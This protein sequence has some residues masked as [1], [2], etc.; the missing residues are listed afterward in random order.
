MDENLKVKA[1]PNI[2]IVL[3]YL[4]VAALLGVYFYM[5][6]IVKVVSADSFANILIAALAG[7]GIY[8]TSIYS[9]GGTSV[10]PV[11]LPNSN[12]PVSM[13]IIPETK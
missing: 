10:T 8:K 1:N 9:A 3:D 2:I 6:V 13:K 11:Q 7:L 5:A 12:N 4:A